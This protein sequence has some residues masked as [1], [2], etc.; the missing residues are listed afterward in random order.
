MTRLASRPGFPASAGTFTHVSR[1]AGQEWRCGS[2]GGE[3]AKG[4]PAVQRRVLPLLFTIRC[5]GIEITHPRLRRSEIGSGTDRFVPETAPLFQNPRFAG[6][7]V[8]GATVQRAVAPVLVHGRTSSLDVCSERV[9]GV[10]TCGGKGWLVRWPG[11]AVLAHGSDGL[12]PR[13][14]S[15]WHRRGPSHV[16]GPLR[17][18]ELVGRVNYR[19]NRRAAC[20]PSLV[21]TDWDACGAGSPPSCT[22]RTSRAKTPC[23]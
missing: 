6:V 8:A 17:P 20:S 3:G 19:K 2:A 14:S 7:E 18:P 21:I 13:R 10:E 12:R 11:S 15:A 5:A 9:V 1:P 23:P 22:W 4:R 16:P